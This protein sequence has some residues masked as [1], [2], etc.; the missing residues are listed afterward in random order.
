MIFSYT[1]LCF[2]PDSYKG[3]P[4]LSTEEDLIDLNNKFQTHL[5]EYSL[6][7]ER[8][9]IAHEKNMEAIS[10]L[11]KSTQGLVDTWVTVRSLQKL[12]SWLSSF[13]VLGV[14]I[15]WLHSKFPALFN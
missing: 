13:A 1:Q 14:L 15:A 8:Q 2:L 5:T 4:L 3:M 7:C 12:M 10:K 11:T 9:D 6:R